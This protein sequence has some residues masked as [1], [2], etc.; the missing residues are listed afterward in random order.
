MFGLLRPSTKSVEGTRND[1]EN[2]SDHF[3][4]RLGLAVLGLAQGS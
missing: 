1:T 3:A 2:A 4:L